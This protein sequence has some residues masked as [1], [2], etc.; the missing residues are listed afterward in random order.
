MNKAVLQLQRLRRS[1]IHGFG[2]P[3]RQGCGRSSS[4][5]LGASLAPRAMPQRLMVAGDGTWNKEAFEGTQGADFEIFLD[6]RQ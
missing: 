3:R 6:S 5:E 4:K 2:R 1:R